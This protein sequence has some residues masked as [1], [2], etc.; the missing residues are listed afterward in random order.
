VILDPEAFFRVATITGAGYPVAGGV[1]G[2]A[3]LAGL[4]FRAFGLPFVCDPS[5]SGGFILDTQSVGIKE[6]PGAPFN[7]TANVPSK[8]GVDYAAFGFLA[9]KV[10]NADGIVSV[11]VEPAT[12]AVAARTAGK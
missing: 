7:M 3:N 9:H 8:L 12:P 2:S 4:S 10:L 1:V 11:V 5:I 6:S